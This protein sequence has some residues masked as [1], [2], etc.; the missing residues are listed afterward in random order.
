M[1]GQQ[2][3]DTDSGQQEAQ[4]HLDKGLP[5]QEVQGRQGNHHNAEEEFRTQLVSW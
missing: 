3:Y 1:Q 4:R 2:R 5:W